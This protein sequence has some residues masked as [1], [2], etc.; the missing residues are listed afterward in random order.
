MFK[1]KL[2]WKS[3]FLQQPYQSYY[4]KI[5]NHKYKPE[6]SVTIKERI[7]IKTLKTI[8]KNNVSVTLD[9][10]ILQGCLF[11][12]FYYSKTIPFDKY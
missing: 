7:G 10:K 8:L 2:F 12:V 4:Q 11:T 6:I 1:K 5:N 9:Q 3:S